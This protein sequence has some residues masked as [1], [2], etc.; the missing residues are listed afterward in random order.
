MKCGFCAYEFDPARAEQ[1][2]SG[3][4]LVGDCRLVRCP[5]C[6]YEMP[7][8]AKLVSWLRAWQA[9]SQNRTPVHA[10]EATQT[11]KA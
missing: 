10:D 8:E 9:R 2:C 1:A 7:P 11:R 3:C 4:P 5:R 6:G